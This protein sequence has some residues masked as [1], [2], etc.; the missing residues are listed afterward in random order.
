MSTFPWSTSVF[1]LGLTFKIF[2]ERHKGPPQG[3]TC[4]QEVCVMASDSSVY[5]QVKPSPGYREPLG[6][7]LLLLSV[8]ATPEEETCTLGPT[9]LSKFR[10][11]NVILGKADGI[12]L[13]ECSKDNGTLLP[14]SLSISNERKNE[15]KPEQLRCVATT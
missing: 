3:T 13:L 12:L 14:F 9:Y 1:I 6:E 2:P 10:P 8:S 7:G 5:I 4:P 15:P 11:D